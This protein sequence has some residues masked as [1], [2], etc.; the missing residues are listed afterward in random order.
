MG[1]QDADGWTICCASVWFPPPSC[2][3]F[4]K[5]G[6]GMHP[7]PVLV[8]GNYPTGVI[9]PKQE[10]K[11]INNRIIRSETLPSYDI[12]ILRKRPSGG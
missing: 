8:G 11:E 9:E 12:L 10:M 3:Q 5:D 1:W 2:F 7:I 4:H 6:K